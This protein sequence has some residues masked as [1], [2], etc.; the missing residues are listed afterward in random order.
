M[1]KNLPSL[2][3]IVSLLFAMTRAGF[4]RYYLGEAVSKLRCPHLASKKSKLKI[5]KRGF[6][7]GCRVQRERVGGGTNMEE[8]KFKTNYM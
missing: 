8:R 7:V 6:G 3:E 1:S 5:K 4:A 2:R